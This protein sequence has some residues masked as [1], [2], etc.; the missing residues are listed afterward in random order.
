[1]SI[2]FVH[3]FFLLL[4][5]GIY[6]MLHCLRLEFEGEQV[7]YYSSERKMSS[8]PSDNSSSSFGNLSSSLSAPPPPP[9]HKFSSSHPK[10]LTLPSHHDGESN[11]SQDHSYRDHQFDV[12]LPVLIGIV[13]GVGVWD[14]FL[15]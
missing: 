14:Y 8:P 12:N 2:P 3:N 13:A 11:H 7:D 15:C 10:E 5:V 4:F 1:M 6:H 9:P